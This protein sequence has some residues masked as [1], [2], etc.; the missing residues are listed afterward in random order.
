MDG[1]FPRLATLA[2]AGAFAVSDTTLP[3]M[4]QR[5]LDRFA[6]GL[7]LVLDSIATRIT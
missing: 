4:L 5:A 3:Y 6:F 7:E 1:R 2:Q